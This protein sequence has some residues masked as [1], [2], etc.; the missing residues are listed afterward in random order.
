MNTDAQHDT[1]VIPITYTC[2]SPSDPAVTVSTSRTVVIS[3]VCDSSSLGL[4][5]NQN[6]ITKKYYFEDSSI[7]YY[8]VAYSF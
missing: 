5:S 4:V 1:Y 6:I 3:S 2:T 7:Y 8:V